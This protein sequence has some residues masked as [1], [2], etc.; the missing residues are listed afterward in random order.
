MAQEKLDTKYPFRDIQMDKK[1]P[2]L[3]GGRGR[4]FVGGARLQVWYASCLIE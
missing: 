1:Y 3:Q 2:D 4:L